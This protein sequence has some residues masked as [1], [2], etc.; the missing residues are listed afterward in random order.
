MSLPA[1]CFIVCVVWYWHTRMHLRQHLFAL[2]T[3]CAGVYVYCLFKLVRPWNGS[4]V[5]THSSSQRSSI[6][7]LRHTHLYTSAI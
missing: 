3:L 2:I 1:L 4:E 6:H 5:Y 7:S